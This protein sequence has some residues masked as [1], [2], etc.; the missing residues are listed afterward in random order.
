MAGSSFSVDVAAIRER[1]RE[2][3]KMNQGAVTEHACDIVD[4]LAK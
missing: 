1:A 3:E 4:L 2:K